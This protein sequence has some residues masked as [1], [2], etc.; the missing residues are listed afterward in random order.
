MATARRIDDVLFMFTI[1]PA[2]ALPPLNGAH[3]RD[4]SVVA[5]L[6]YYDLFAFPLRAGELERFAHAAGASARLVSGELPTCTPWWDSGD[7]YY[8]LK[9]RE[10]LTARRA[11]LEQISAHKLALARRWARLLQLIPGVRFIGVTGSLAMASA[12]PEDDIDF[13]IIAARDRL[14]V[15]RA[16]VLSALLALGVKRLD[17][18]RHEQ[19]DR[20]CAN[21]FLRE[22]NL[23]MPDRNLF[24]AHEIC[25]MMPLLGPETYGRFL[26][27]NR[28]T[29]EYLPHWQPQPSEW[30]DRPGWRQAQSAFE[31]TFGNGLGTRVDAELARRQR[32]RIQSK[33]ARGH[34][35][36]VRLSETQLRFHANDLSQYIVSTFDAYW[37]I[38]N[39]PV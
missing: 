17:N 22:D 12:V 31:R 25:Q 6:L 30:L 37:Q 2:P 28:W 4:R 8:F 33:H 36:G 10:Q 39:H 1:Q 7:G 35:V 19:P 9:G 21:I 20:V 14:W 15:T 29:R 24:I 11:R 38:L 5:T 16:L 18:G 13:L 34:N 27:A 23:E 3:D 32:A 26:E